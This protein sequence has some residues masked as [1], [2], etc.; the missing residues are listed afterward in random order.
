[1]KPTTKRIA[2]L[3]VLTGLALASYILES[4]LPNLLLPGAKIG[5]SNVFS[6]LTLILLGLPQALL[7]TAVRTTIAAL[8]CGTVGALPYSLTAGIASVIVAYLAYTAT[9][10]KTS[11]VATSIAGAVT[12]NLVQNAVYSAMIRSADAF[13][14]SP[15]LGLFGIISGLFTGL[16]TLLILKTIPDAII[17]VT[18][19]RRKN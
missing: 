11:V 15:Y 10:K 3:G 13:A 7:L 1:M 12:H 8:V 19:E 17:D 14:L 5:I 6:L 2:L 4:L 9:K 18:R 16:L